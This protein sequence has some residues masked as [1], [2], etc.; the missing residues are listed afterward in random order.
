[1]KRLQ[2]K[3]IEKRSKIQ[4]ASYFKKPFRKKNVLFIYPSV[5]LKLRHQKWKLFERHSWKYL[6]Y[7]Y[8]KYKSP[9]SFIK[10]LTSKKQYF[11]FSLK[12][13][14]L[15]KVIYEIPSEKRFK[16]L[17]RQSFKRKQSRQKF[18]SLLQRRLDF[19]LVRIKYASS[20][21]KSRFLINH[22]FIKINDKIVSQFHHIVKCNDIISIDF[23]IRKYIYKQISK[24]HYRKMSRKTY[25][26]RKNEN[27][28]PRRNYLRIPKMIEINYKTLD[29]ILFKDF[30]IRSYKTQYDLNIDIVHKLYR[31]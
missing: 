27:K 16:N 9:L 10:R 4:W 21:K 25:R 8:F 26:G 23:R 13:K 3:K 2:K 28:N 14:Q 5:F 31:R 15:F 30:P 1:M 11:R 20:I 19:F 18:Y 17:L 24:F 22:K 7:K 29:V 12:Q 6:R